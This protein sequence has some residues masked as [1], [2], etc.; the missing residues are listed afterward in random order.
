M[1]RLELRNGFLPNGTIFKAQAGLQEA[2]FKNLDFSKA[3]MNAF[4]STAHH[5]HSLKLDN[6]P[7]HFAGDET[8]NP[9]STLR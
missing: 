5:L 3:W 2:V 1:T 7:F 4:T 8:L 9:V 6:C